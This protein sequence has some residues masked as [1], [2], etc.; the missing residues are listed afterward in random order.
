MIEFSFLRNCL[1]N[2]VRTTFLTLLVH[3]H[4]PSNQ[5]AFFFSI[6]LWLINQT[7][8]GIAELELCRFDGAKLSCLAID[9]LW[10]AINV[11]VFHGRKNYSIETTLLCVITVPQ[12]NTIEKETLSDI[13]RVFGLQNKNQAVSP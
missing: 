6:E 4:F 9:R 7:G 8:I 11:Y 1:F 13:L 10:S 3:I 2:Q 12:C 5:C